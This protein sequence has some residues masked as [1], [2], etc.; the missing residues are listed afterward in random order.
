[1]A[2]ELADE[3]SAGSDDREACFAMAIEAFFDCARECPPPTCGDRC[4][5]KARAYFMECPKARTPVF[6]TP[7]RRDRSE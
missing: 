1:V 2:L 3:C 7:V 6:C 5:A 4:E